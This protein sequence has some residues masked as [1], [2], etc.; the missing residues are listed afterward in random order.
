MRF[1]TAVTVLDYGIGNL[2]NVVRALEYVG[3]SVNVADSAVALD[4]SGISRL[5]LPGV[6]AFGDAVAEIRSRG[7][8]D[9]VT[10]FVDA[11]RPF[12]GI[13]VGFQ[14]MFEASNEQGSHRGLGLWSGQVRPVPAVGATGQSHRVPHVGWRPLLAEQE[15]AGTPLSVL[16]PNDRMYFVHSFAPVPARKDI[17]LASV[18]YD[19]VRLCAAARAG[20]AIGCQFHP[21]RSG[22]AGLRILAAF[23]DL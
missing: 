7:I 21:E 2:H 13:C 14:V 16:R 8:D 20:A 10:R 5:V 3:A 15:W 11:G 4:A 1:A 9:L 12:L 19:G 18:D 17:W 6:G 23:M 22:E